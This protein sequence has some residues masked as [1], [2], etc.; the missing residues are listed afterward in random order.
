M[1]DGRKKVA[2]RPKKVVEGYMV[3]VGRVTGGEGM[4]EGAEGGAEL[5]RQRQK[6][7]GD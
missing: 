1:T 2:T 4:K 7:V 3:F 6:Q 5:Y